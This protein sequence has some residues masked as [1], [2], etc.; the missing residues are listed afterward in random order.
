M[1][2]TN[3]S[4]ILSYNKMLKTTYTKTQ[5]YVKTSFDDQ[6][7]TRIDYWFQ[8]LLDELGGSGNMLFNLI[9][10]KYRDIFRA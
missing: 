8:G 5:K 6:E 3:W 4:F 9:I 2:G 10:I 1:C 7:L